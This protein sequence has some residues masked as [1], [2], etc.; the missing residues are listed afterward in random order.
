MVRIC[1]GFSVAWPGAAPAAIPLRALRGAR[2]SDLLCRL[3][4]GTPDIRQGWDSSKSKEGRSAFHTDCGQTACVAIKRPRSQGQ[5]LWLSIGSGEE[6]PGVT[7][8]PW[9]SVSDA[10]DLCGP[11]PGQKLP[12]EACPTLSR[13]LKLGGPGV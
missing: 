3:T 12:P 4:R 2:R 11:V 7:G 6:D 1:T 9:L 13:P 10:T 8:D 5:G